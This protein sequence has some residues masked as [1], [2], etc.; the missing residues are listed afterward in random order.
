MPSNST[1]VVS[2]EESDVAFGAEVVEGMRSI[3]PEVWI[4]KHK[5]QRRGN[6]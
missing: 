2:S 3:E 1:D 6:G 5:C 4:C